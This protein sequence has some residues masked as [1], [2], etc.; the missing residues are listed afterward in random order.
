MASSF[1]LE[2]KVRWEE[3]APSLQDKLKALL[4]KWSAGYGWSSNYAGA[5]RI[6]IGPVAPQNCVQYSDIWWDTRYQVLRVLTE[7]GWIL[8]RGAWHAGAN[9]DVE[10]SIDNPLSHNPVTRCHCY[11]INWDAS[12]YC[13]CKVSKWESTETNKTTRTGFQN[14]Y[15]YQDT[16]YSAFKTSGYFI[17]NTGS[18]SGTVSVSSLNFNSE[19]Y[20]TGAIIGSSDPAFKRDSNL[21]TPISYSNTDVSDLDP[22]PLFDGNANT[23]VNFPRGTS[24]KISLK[25]NEDVTVGDIGN[26]Y[27]TLLNN[28]NGP[29]TFELY[30]RSVTN[31]SQYVKVFSI[32]LL[33]NYDP[34][35]ACH[36]SCHCARW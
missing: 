31:A 2:D 21:Y 15:G 5:V 7:E 28:S 26:I 22:S 27:G 23:Y 30:L 13:H 35:V 32:T 33:G 19:K 10:D 16:K 6:T 3:W 4:N 29:V 34:G 24:Y 11:T 12:Q 14:H 25:A 1:N 18:S 9:S 36:H 8:T 17:I 20:P